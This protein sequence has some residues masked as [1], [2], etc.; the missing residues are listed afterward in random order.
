MS[1]VNC[2]LNVFIFRYLP[3]IIIS[4]NNLSLNCGSHFHYATSKPP[5]NMNVDV[6]D[7]HIMKPCIISALLIKIC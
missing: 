4:I 2:V 7:P 1:I 5:L 3:Y 6:T